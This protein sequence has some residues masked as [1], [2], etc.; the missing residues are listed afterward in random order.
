MKSARR[1]GPPLRT[2]ECPQLL[3]KEI[4]PRILHFVTQKMHS[5]EIRSYKDK[6]AVNFIAMLCYSVATHTKSKGILAGCQKFLR[7]PKLRE[8]SAKP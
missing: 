8:I 4:Q 1:S 6:R 5:Y 3:P 2:G 7:F